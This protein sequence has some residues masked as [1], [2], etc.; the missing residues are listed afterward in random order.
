MEEL[1]FVIM[2][3]GCFSVIITCA[4]WGGSYGLNKALKRIENIEKRQRSRDRTIASGIEE[5][6][7]LKE[8][9][10]QLRT[11]LR[12]SYTAFN[13][14]LRLTIDCYNTGK[15]SEACLFCSNGCSIDTADTVE[16]QIINDLKNYGVAFTKSGKAYI[17]M[18][19]EGESDEE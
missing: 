19:D 13:A 2:V 16:C 12:T 3:A 7:I 18:T 10:E 6:K 11:N 17:P 4:F 14:L 5:I 9:H 8:E 15:I 1:G